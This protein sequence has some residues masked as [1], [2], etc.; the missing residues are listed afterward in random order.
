MV[1]SEIMC[2]RFR[3]YHY[4]LIVCTFTWS[5]WTADFNFIIFLWWRLYL[6]RR[7]VYHIHYINSDI[8]CNFVLMATAPFVPYF[9]SSLISDKLIPRGLLCQRKTFS[10]PSFFPLCQYWIRLLLCFI[11]PRPHF[12]HV[13]L[14]K[15]INEN[16]N[17]MCYDSKDVVPSS[18]QSISRKCVSTLSPLYD[19]ME[20]H[21]NIMDENNWR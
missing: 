11:W 3:G 2:T 18:L 21:D 19:P 1:Y 14:R 7:G 6:R 9:I 4:F 13:S 17:A 12:Q 15:I 20:E 16:V 8:R 5:L 10:F